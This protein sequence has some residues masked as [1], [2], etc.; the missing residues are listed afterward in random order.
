MKLTTRPCIS[1]S[2]T[3]SSKISTLKG[4]KRTGSNS[5]SKSYHLNINYARLS[6]EQAILEERLRKVK[7]EVEMVKEQLRGG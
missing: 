3:S 2:S 5:F 6:K 4:R 1:S 7:D